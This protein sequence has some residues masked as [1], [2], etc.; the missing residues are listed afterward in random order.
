MLD[1][2]INHG[3]SFSVYRWAIGKDS[4]RRERCRCLETG[5]LQGR[6]RSSCKRY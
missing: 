6:E 1:M 4:G 2:S 5:T 3:I